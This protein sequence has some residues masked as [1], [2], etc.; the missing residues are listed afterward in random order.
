MKLS[1][2]PPQ[3]PQSLLIFLGDEEGIKIGSQDP[4]PCAIWTNQCI[5][6]SKSPLSSVIFLAW[7][8]CGKISKS[9]YIQDLTF[10]MRSWGL[11]FF[12]GTCPS[13]SMATHL[14]GMLALGGACPCF[15]GCIH[16]AS[17]K[18]MP[19]R[20]LHASV[21]QGLSHFICPWRDPFLRW[22]LCIT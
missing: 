8:F 7:L 16:A 18:F 22:G 4:L 21:L 17:S 9:S 13:G 1:L 11:Y 19:H 5:G 3:I 2:C 6:T 15:L 20:I 14:W 12:Q 10:R